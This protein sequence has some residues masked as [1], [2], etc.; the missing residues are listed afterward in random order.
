ML[1]MLLR[2]LREETATLLLPIAFLQG[3]LL[4]QL[5]ERLGAGLWP[6]DSPPWILCLYAVIFVGAGMLLLGLEQANKAKVFGLT[7]LF[8]L[9]IGALAYYRGSQI[10][11]QVAGPGDSPIIFIFTL[12]AAVAAFKALMYVQHF[13]C[14]EAFSYSNL[15]RWSWR[16]FL[17]FCL[18]LLFTKCVWAVLFL[19]AGLFKIINI[20]YFFD[21]FTEVWFIY[22]ATA[23][24]FGLGVAVFHKQSRVIDA[25]ASIQQAL[26][27]FLLPLLVLA[28]GAFI[29]TLPF[30]GLEPLWENGGSVLILCMQ[31][32]LFFFL[33]AVYKDDPAERPYPLWVHRFIYAGIALMPLY[34]A[35]SCYGLSLRVMQYGWSISRCWGFLLWALLALFAVGYCWGI[36]RRRDQWLR[37]LGWL[38]VR[39]G[40][41]VLA[42]MLAVNSPLL[43]FRKI[44]V[45]SQMARLDSGAVS[46]EEFDFEYFANYLDKPGYDALQDLKAKVSGANPEV[47]RKIDDLYRERKDLTEDEIWQLAET[48]VGDYPQTLV[49]PIYETM[50]NYSSRRVSKMTFHLLPLDLDRDGETDYLMTKTGTHSSDSMVLFYREAGEW[51]TTTLDYGR[52]AHNELGETADYDAVVESLRRGEFKIA[53]PRWNQIEVDGITLHARGN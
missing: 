33:N 38:N 5:G 10:V 34:S 12:T 25:V 31:A 28:A 32:V 35:L 48:I 15:F 44:S 17:I 52:Y 40:L 43:D 20:D 47:A 8:T 14:G 49:Q 9:L 36:I 26:M 45:H 13:A 50:D 19:W 6:A 30:A 46:L 4:W 16:N 18:A 42:A 51:K 3:L 11:P 2:S 21:L 41:V 39:M 24:A 53:S 27:K 7:V 1:K 22:L 23:L 29:V 37:S